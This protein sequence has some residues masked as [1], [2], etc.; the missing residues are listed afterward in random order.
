MACKA[1][2]VMCLFAMTLSSCAGLWPSR[3]GGIVPDREA[4][5]I[6]TK[7]QCTADF[8]YHYSGSDLYPS[9]L[10]G[11]RKDIRLEE[12]TL[13]KKIDMTPDIDTYLRH[14]RESN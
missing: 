14:E 11:V 3:I 4:S 6:F 13:W 7:G 9:A 10:I 12:D 2:A 1:I 8:Q 5:Q